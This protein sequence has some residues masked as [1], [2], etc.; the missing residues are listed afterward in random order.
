M[1]TLEWLRRALWCWSPSSQSQYQV[2]SHWRW[3]RVPS[4]GFG[5]IR[6]VR[7]WPD[8]RYDATSLLSCRIH[9]KPNYADCVL[10]N[11]SKWSNCSAPCNDG[12]E[13][14]TMP[15]VHQNYHGGKP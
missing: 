9:T 15:I 1:A 7:Y 13:T 6:E 3:R 10:G 5:G 12:V 11:W 4:R 14:K 2:F 8:L